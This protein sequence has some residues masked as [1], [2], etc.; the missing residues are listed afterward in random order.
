MTKRSAILVS[1]VFSLLLAVAAAC[2]ETIPDPT[3]TATP[4]ES[5]PESG[6]TAEPTAEPEP[7][8]E[9]PAV[10]TG[11]VTYRE[12]IALSPQ[13]VVEV[14]LEDVSRADA[15]AVTIGEQTITNPGQVPIDFEIEYDPSAI[16]D[17][18]TYAIRV[19]ITEGERLRFIN[20]SQYAVITRGSPSH[21]D[22]VLEMVGSATDEQPEVEPVAFEMGPCMMTLAAQ[23]PIEFEYAGTVPTGF[24][25]INRANC[26][27]TRPVETVEVVLTGPTTH[28]E[29]FTL[30]KV[31]T[32]VSFPLPE[33]TLSIT[34][35]EIVAP[36]EYQRE[37]TV[38]SVD[39]D[40]LVV[41]DQPGVLK[42]VTVLEPVVFEMGPCR[43]TAATQLPIEFEY[44][45]TVPTGFDGIN[46]AGC[47]FTKEVETV[48]VTL[49]GPATHTELF[50]LGEPTKDVS[51]PLR[52]GTLSIS[53]LEIVP[54]GKYDR[55]ITVTSVDGE[56][57]VVS[58]QPGVLK[59]VSI[60]EPVVFEMGPCRTTLAARLPIEFEYN[61]TVPTGFD[62]I[63]QAGCT[64]TKPVKSVTVTLTGPATHSE[65]FTL[66]EPTTDVSFPL[67]EGTL[68]I[69][70]LEIVPP[71]EY[72]REI[73]VTSVDGDVLVVSDQPGVLNT[74][75]ILKP[76]AFEMGPCAMT[77]AVQL[78]IEFEY[79][80][81]IPT[82]FDGINRANCTFTKAVETVTVTLSGP[83]RHTETF[84][85]ADPTT[86]VSFP[87]PE[88]TLSITTLEIVPPGEYDREI[89]VT[90]VDGDVLVVSDQPGVLKTVTILEP[91]VF[92]AGPCS[93]TRAAQLPIE[94]EY[95]GTVPTGFDGIN[96]A[97][98]SFTKDVKTVTVTIMGPHTH[99]ETFTLS[100]PT[101]EVSFLLPE[102]TL[103]ITTLEIVPPGEYQREMKVTS[104]DGETLVISDQP[105]VLKTVT[106]IEPVA[107]QVEVC[108]AT[109]AAQLPIE[110]EYNGTIP[111]GFDGINRASC[112]FT[113]A[114]K[115]V[116]VTITGPHTHS[117]TFTLAEPTE[118]VS[119]PLPEGT[120]SIT[121]LEIVPPGD[122]QREI[123][124]DSLVKSLCRSN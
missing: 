4:P 42:T 84:T 83:A 6:A 123:K 44:A 81:T 76:V 58:D 103:S 51:F 53:T 91:V 56:T 34:T 33:G 1:V 37:I 70:T 116:T 98:C 104:V 96:R 31:D 28:T 72:E 46:R 32:R 114:V 10:V 64:F 86:A 111:T 38:T 120:L 36:G 82:G 18:F 50:T 62:G 54:P 55:E 73:T 60:L 80:G 112:T 105:G 48:T 13:A 87:L 11:T 71:G 5:Q 118:Q 59:T 90:S 57:L 92:E 99:S 89:T 3:A 30:A 47:T 117:E 66:G 29:V 121:T 68:S 110:F 8:S 93:M 61:G 12:R 94:F 97:N 115:T 95:A 85:V 109:L 79:T 49:T 43:M 101:S 27:F 9:P 24:D 39:G 63:N 7:T 19:R 106:I 15:A 65:Q 40:T 74:V 23:L 35:L 14:K 22:M 45:G 108:I 16:D 124:D 77:L 107:F 21:V 113:K 25:G 69:T 67:P 119:F 26:T 88:G 20:T 17:R 100:E 75:T 52:E 122:Y 102:G 41:S 78:P 2:G